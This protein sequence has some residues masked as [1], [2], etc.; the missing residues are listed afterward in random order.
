MALA[1]VPTTAAGSQDTSAVDNTCRPKNRI[2]R[3]REVPKRHGR[4]SAEE[5]DSDK[6]EA[7]PLAHFHERELDRVRDQHL[8]YCATSSIRAGRR[9][10][11][12]LKPES[13]WFRGSKW[14]P[15]NEWLPERT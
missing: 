12:T 10:H 14:S 15:E 6:L 4:R 3:L 2:Q 1:L 7:C 5:R 11:E 13:E 8:P 9:D